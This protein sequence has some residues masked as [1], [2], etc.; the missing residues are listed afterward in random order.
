MSNFA[1]VRANQAVCQA[2][3]LDPNVTAKVVVVLDPVR[4]VRV[5]ARQYVL[6]RDAERLVKVVRR[7]KVTEFGAEEA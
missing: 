7:F 4:P 1:S 5:Y 3:G 2:L 6:D